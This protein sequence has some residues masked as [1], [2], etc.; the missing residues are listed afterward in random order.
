MGMDADYERGKWSNIEFYIDDTRYSTLEEFC[1]N[2]M[3]D[4]DRFIET[5]FISI[6]EDEDGGDPRNN[7]LFEKSGLK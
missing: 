3:I 6:L 1:E 2:C 7:V 5:E 4:G